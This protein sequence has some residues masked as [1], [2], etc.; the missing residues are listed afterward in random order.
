MSIFKFTNEFKNQALI[1]LATIAAATVFKLAQE[2]IVDKVK[3]TVG[4]KDTK[5]KA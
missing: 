5:K 2:A 1:T 3:A 4:V